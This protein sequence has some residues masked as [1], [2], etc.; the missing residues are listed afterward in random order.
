MKLQTQEKKLSALAVPQNQG[1]ATK[2]LA[3]TLPLSSVVVD[4]AVVAFYTLSM[5]HIPARGISEAKTTN[6]GIFLH[7]Y[8]LAWS[9]IFSATLFLME[10]RWTRPLWAR[11][12]NSVSEG[13][14]LQG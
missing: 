2:R 12:Q 4:N 13:E 14:G 8:S 3:D 11:V 1:G 7:A 6:R 10:F 9:I 5:R